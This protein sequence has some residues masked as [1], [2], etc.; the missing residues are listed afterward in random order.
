MP[1]KP[2]GE[3][4]ANTS[5]PPAKNPPKSPKKDYS[6]LPQKPIKLKKDVD[7]PTALRR[8]ST[9]PPSKKARDKSLPTP[10]KPRKPTTDKSRARNANQWTLRGISAEAKAIAMN[11]ATQEDIKVSEWLERLIM[12]SVQPQ[13]KEGIGI[14][15]DELSAT[16]HSID[17]RLERLEQQKG[18]WARFWDQFMDQSKKKD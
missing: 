10:K 11:A 2:D 15:E 1:N 8:N 13:Q 4:T 9:K 12:Q 3:K 16:L 18:F 17:T 5:V 6:S 7:V 14:T